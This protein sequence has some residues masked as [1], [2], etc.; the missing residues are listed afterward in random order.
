MTGDLNPSSN[1]DNFCAQQFQQLQRAEL[2]DMMNGELPDFS[3]GQASFNMN[4]N[5]YCNN[6]P[7]ESTRVK[8]KARGRC[9]GSD[10]I[11]ASY[12]RVPEP[13]PNPSPA[14][15]PRP[16]EY[17]AAQAPLSATC[18][19][20][21]R[22][23]LEC[24]VRLVVMLTRLNEGDCIKAHR[25][26]PRCVGRS[27]RFGDIS[28]RLVS[29]HS[30][31]GTGCSDLIVRR[32]LVHA[33]VAQKQQDQPETE[34]TRQ[35]PSAKEEW[36]EITHLHYQ[37]WP[38]FGRPKMDSF[39]E[40]LRLVD[41]ARTTFP[42]VPVITHCSA[43]LG[44]TGVLIAA[45]IALCHLRQGVHPNVLAI[46]HHIRKQRPGLVQTLEQ[47]FFIYQVIGGL[48]TGQAPTQATNT[49]AV[50]GWNNI[51]AETYQRTNRT[52]LSM[53]TPSSWDNNPTPAMSHVVAFD[54]LMHCDASPRD[55]AMKI[56]TKPKRRGR[57]GLSSSSPAICM[58]A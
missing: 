9:L 35:A 28:L 12:V 30:H 6:L 55:D 51:S 57:Q 13:L 36:H 50:T 4:K 2:D 43:G 52:T 58:R 19:D 22:M 40:L 47:F 17:I 21:W 24:G 1:T 45:H 34:G 29:E 41:I 10:Y 49:T 33:Q 27:K 32:V 37:A 39:R 20:F 7:L 38:D 42:E 18:E 46:V 11:N 14:Q 5:R 56:N 15:E 16:A 23:V 31:Y 44:R 26:W 3:S 25:Y 54:D 53:S 8:L 48:L